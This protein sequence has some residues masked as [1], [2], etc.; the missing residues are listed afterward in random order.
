MNISDSSDSN[1]NSSGKEN[2]KLLS[3]KLVKSIRNDRKGAI[4]NS[5]ELETLSVGDIDQFDMKRYRYVEVKSKLVPKY[6]MRVKLDYPLQQNIPKD[7]L[8]PGNKYHITDAK[9]FN[10]SRISPPWITLRP[11]IVK[12]H[13]TER[14]YIS[15][16]KF[17]RNSKRRRYDERNLRK[18][19]R[20]KQ[21]SS[22]NSSSS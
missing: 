14:S 1:N 16:K 11:G 8:V 15:Y 2:K 13:K 18:R 5:G 19:K 3:K 17:S 22:S 9:I 7:V 20:R 12:M 21:R 10:L 6:Q 4:V